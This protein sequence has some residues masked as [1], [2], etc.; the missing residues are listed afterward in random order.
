MGEKM[1]NA[2]LIIIMAIACCGCRTFMEYEATEFAQKDV[3]I[4]KSILTKNPCYAS[5]RKIA[6]KGLML[7]S[8]GCPVPSGKTW[9]QAWNKPDYDRACVH[10][11]IDAHTGIVFQTLPWNH[12]GW[13]AGGKANDTHI[14]V[15]MCESEF[16][17]YVGGATFECSNIEKSQEMAWRTY[18]SAVNLFAYLCYKFNL[19]PLERGVII[20]HNEGHALGVASGHL[21]PEHLWRQLN[22][23][24]SMDTFRKDVSDKLKEY[25]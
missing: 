14:G 21:D 17:K 8:V 13:H 24:I 5:G 18:H 16:L 25:K 6:V 3:V 15:E 19:D 12:R 20:S 11:F 23:P 10:A 1:K 2:I 22:M 7:H 9:V 4:Q